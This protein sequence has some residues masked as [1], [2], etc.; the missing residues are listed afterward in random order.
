MFVT[1]SSYSWSELCHSLPIRKAG[2]EWKARRA[3]VSVAF[4]S[5][6]NSNKN[7]MTDFLSNQ[8]WLFNLHS[9]TKPLKSRKC[10]CTEVSINGGLHHARYKK[11][12]LHCL[13]S[14]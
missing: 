3:V 13:M 6:R 5:S 2:Y 11:G 8:Y 12:R 4:L 7:V 1:K 10:L 14:E 9:T